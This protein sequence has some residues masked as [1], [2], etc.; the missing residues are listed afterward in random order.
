MDKVINRCPFVM[1]CEFI[2]IPLVIDGGNMV[3]CKGRRNIIDTEYVVM[4]EKML[5][6][7][8]S[9]S[10]QQIETILKAAFQNPDL[11]LVWLPWDKEDTFGHTDGIVRYVGISESGKPKVLVNL[12]VYDDAI[13]NRMYDILT[14]HFEVVEIKLSEYDELS[15]AYI[16]SLQTQEFI[17]VPGIG[18]SL[19][20]EE[21]MSQY[22]EL[23]P[24]YK[25]NIY[26]VQMRDFIAENG[27][28]LNCLTWT[29]Y[30]DFT[31][32]LLSGKYIEKI[33]SD[34]C[35]RLPVQKSIDDV[36][37]DMPPF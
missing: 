30:E 18:N 9:F 23:F 36:L 27:G 12:E 8:P 14:Q 26:M 1:D 2:N 31:R 16:N 25:D 17:I 11:T 19:T 10:R 37:K 4:T 7:N 6:E 29:L 20:D 21:A 24:Q 3:F 32:A 5:A 35:K 28:A 15:W 13:A 22:K 34:D 33:G